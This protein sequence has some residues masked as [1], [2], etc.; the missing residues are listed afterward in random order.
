MRFFIIV[1]V[2]ALSLPF[3]L[4]QEGTRATPS[5]YGASLGNE[6]AQNASTPSES[7]K[8]TPEAYNREH[9]LIGEPR[10]EIHREGE[11]KSITGKYKIRDVKRLYLDLNI[12]P[13]PVD[14]HLRA[15][16]Q[17]QLSQ[18]RYNQYGMRFNV[19]WGG[20][21]PVLPNLTLKLELRGVMGDTPTKKTLFC[22]FTDFRRGS[23]WTE[24]EISG[25][26]Y[27]ALGQLTAW[28]VSLI[29]DGQVLAEKR[30]FL[31]R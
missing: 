16:Y 8:P 23:R 10:Q 18:S 9:Q 20:E 21:G 17:V 29:S 30:S 3:C 22:D 4:A 1:F 31:W 26:D 6:E 13:G 24:I 11:G 27:R 19:H 14:P 25:D 7:V 12:S 28:K 15:N 2:M 5:A